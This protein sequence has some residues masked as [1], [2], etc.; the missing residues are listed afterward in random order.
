[1]AEAGD[2]LG[3]GRLLKEVLQAGHGER[4]QA[5]SK[6]SVHYRM[7]R[8]GSEEVLDS[9]NG[10]GRP[11]TFTLGQDDV[12]RG[13]EHAVTTMQVGERSAFTVHPDLAFGS[14]GCGG[15]IPPSSDASSLSLRV[16][17]DLLDV[18][19]DEAAE[20][21]A[22]EL[23]PE[24]RLQRG[25]R[26]KDAGNA[27]FK[28]GE[29]RLAV[30]SYVKALQLLECETV[31]GFEEEESRRWMDEVQCAERRKLALSCALNLAQCELKLGEFASA[32][33]HGSYALALEPTSSK[34]L[35]RRGIASM[36]LGDLNAAKVDLLA[37]ARRE[38]KNV[39]IRSQLEESQSRLQASNDRDRIAFG[40]MF[41]RGTA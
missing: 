21:G 2:V 28:S 24:E 23:S 14:A 38:P 16:E 26:A 1:M 30:A 19:A 37:A 6:V 17:V 34:A 3:D 7:R 33:Q 11:F 35:Y 36:E 22:E 12:I 41:D 27:Q 4:P 25:L 15:A 31:S 5:Q 10:R 40:R 8:V 9:S 13:L 20:P 18:D 29:L 32:A 39:E